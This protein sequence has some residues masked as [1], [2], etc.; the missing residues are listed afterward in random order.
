L[1]N[2]TQKGG[3]WCLEKTD[4]IQK[5]LQKMY[6]GIWG[7]AAGLGS[8]YSL[9]FP[10]W[11]KYLSFISNRRNFIVWKQLNAIALPAS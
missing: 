2:Q 7:V 5:D 3:D 1:I 4:A 11:E 6:S 8:V 9:T 10:P